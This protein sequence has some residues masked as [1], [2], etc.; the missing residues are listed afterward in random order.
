MFAADYFAGSARYT[1]RSGTRVRERL[2][3]CRS[4]ELELSRCYSTGELTD[5]TE[6]L[7]YAVSC[8]TGIT[9]KKTGNSRVLFLVFRIKHNDLKTSIT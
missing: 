2:T 7:W 3:M 9:D 4:R 1:L 8:N 5:R 6:S